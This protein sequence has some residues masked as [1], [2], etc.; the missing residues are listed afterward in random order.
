LHG[1]SRGSTTVERV[2]VKI[3]ILFPRIYVAVCA[4]GKLEITL[5]NRI[6][7]GSF[8]A[9]KTR[10]DI[11]DVIYPPSRLSSQGLRVGGASG[12]IVSNSQGVTGRRVRG[13]MVVLQQEIMKETMIRI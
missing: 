9:R 6:G 7:D 10:L 2:A 13:A 12:S 4:S 11:P 8:T 5:G 3:L 1:S